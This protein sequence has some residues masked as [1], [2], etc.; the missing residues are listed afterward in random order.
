MSALSLLVHT[1]NVHTSHRGQ[2]CSYSCIQVMCTPPHRGQH[3]PYSCIQ[4]V[5]HLAQRSALSLLI[6][7][8]NVHTATEVSTV[9]T[10][11]YRLCVHLPQ[12]S[13]L[14]L[15]VHTGNVHTCDRGQHSPYLYIQVM[16]TPPRGQ[17]CSYSC[18]QVMCTPPTDV[19]T[20]PTCAYRE[21]AH[22]PQRSVLLLLVHT[23]NVHISHRGQHS[24]YSCIQVMCTPPSPQRSAL[25][26][27][28]HTGNV[29]T[30]HR[31][32]HCPYLCIQVMCTPP[33]EVSSVP[34]HPY[35]QR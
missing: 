25:S 31:C 7:T 5:T 23:G 28:I 6:H 18:I 35:R 19:S 8:S 4:V 10:C 15:L 22:L 1:G 21:C 33:T 3:C 17:H 27:L 26:L 30:S 9:P 13:A 16:C 12:R 2:Y 11:A 24:P 29:H 14:Y 32:Q 20:V 34:T